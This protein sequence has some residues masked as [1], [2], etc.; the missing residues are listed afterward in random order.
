MATLACPKATIAFAACTNAASRP[1]ASAAVSAAPV[2]SRSARLAG[3]LSASAA[4][5]AAACSG[6]ELFSTPVAHSRGNPGASRA[7]SRGAVR[8][9]ASVARRKVL[10]V[11][12][13]GGGHAVIGFALARQLATAGHSVTIMTVG[14]R[15]SD[16]MKKQPFSRFSE[17]RAEG[18]RTEWGDPARLSAVFG[19]TG[20]FDVV[21]DNNGKD[22]DTVK[23]VADWASAAGVRQFLFI[24]SAGIYTPS[25]ETPHVEGDAVKESSGHAQVEKYLAGKAWGDGWAAFRPQYITGSGNNKD[26]E[27]WFFDRIVRGRPVPIPSPGIQLTVVAHVDDIARMIALAIDYPQDAKGQIFNAVGG[28]AV[29]FDGLARMCA[30]AAGRASSLKIVHYDPKA[31]GVDAKKAFPFRNMHFYSEPRNARERLGF[32]SFTDLQT[33]LNQRYIDYVAAGRDKKDAKFETRL[34]PTTVPFLHPSSLRHFT[35]RSPPFRP[36]PLRSSRCDH[37]G[38]ASMSGIGRALYNVGFWVRETGQALDRLGCRL[39]GKYAFHEELSR[40]RTIMNLFDK[41]PEVPA[42]A[43]VAPSA[44]V[45]GDVQ[46]GQ[47]SS[48]WYN[49][50]LRGDVN[51]I[52]VGADTNI[53]DGCIVHV[54]K[55]NL[56]GKILPTIIGSRVTVGHNAILHACTVEDEAFVGIGATLLDGVV[57]ESGAMVA[58]GALVVQN[59]RIPSGQIWAG[60][61]AKFFRTLTAAERAFIAKSAESYA[62]LAE[63]HAKENAKSFEEVEADKKQREGWANYSEDFVSSVG[64]VVDKPPVP[65]PVK[66]A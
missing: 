6:K 46:I 29:T 13:N 35:R 28:R 63:V 19:A 9:D 33:V 60:S 10:I 21:L 16:K 8:V 64:A 54:A 27:E 50:I 47:R 18:V 44:A 2:S 15:N 26:C 39:Q 37:R 55:T 30:N 3:S 51:S 36:S 65:G 20:G 4:A 40:H 42:N 7:V 22:L 14:D 49:A 58:A 1:A 43:F 32:K 11:N 12:T 45:I 66:L 34:H 53:Q 59:T 17:L 23:P 38:P 24:S 25:S 57:V 56:A 62:S 31:A 5:A 61:P 41:L 52:R 48:V